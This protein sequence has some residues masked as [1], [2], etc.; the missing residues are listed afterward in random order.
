MSACQVP[1]GD[2][3]AGYEADDQA[4][5]DGIDNDQDG[6]IDCMDV[7]CRV[8]STLCGERVPLYRN[9]QP[10]NAPDTCHDQVDNDDD[11]LF[12]CGDRSCSDVPETCCRVEFS[13]RLCSDGIDNDSN[14]YTDCGEFT[15][16]SG[17]VAV[18][19]DERYCHLKPDG[20]IVPDDACCSDGKDS[21][22]DGKT[23]CLDSNC[24]SACPKDEELSVAACSDGKD[25][26]G[27]GYVDCKDFDCL[28]S[29]DPAVAALCAVPVTPKPPEDTEAACMNG[30]DDD[31]NGYTDCGDFSCTGLSI[32]SVQAYCLEKLENTFAKCQ[33]GK[34]N[35][36]NGYTDC[37]DRSC[38]AGYVTCTDAGLC[39][40]F[41][42]KDVATARACVESVA[43]SVKEMNELCSNGLDE[44][45]DGFVDCADFDCAR[46]PGVTVC[47]DKPRMCGTQWK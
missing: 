12:D 10:E 1:S 32:E 25:N 18:C 4:C 47:A 31:G 27:N 13:D 16:K 14:G 38:R 21:D 5:D 29:K 22:G 30:K 34:D 26:N 20:S 7:D 11:G 46:A 8:A 3:P 15:C 6:L 40:Y 9:F 45:H 33:D 19:M 43:S 44:D 37:D 17:F 41:T 39:G 24:V 42:T 2:P 28:K 23:D 36:G 35:D